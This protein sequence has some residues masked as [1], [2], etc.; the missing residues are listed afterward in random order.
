MKRTPGHFA[1]IFIFVTVLLCMV[2]FGV[3]IPVMPALIMEV[4]GGDLAEAAKWGGVLTLVYAIMQFF[5]MPI[6]GG[7]SDR[8]GRR[9]VLLGSLAAYSLDFLMLALAPNIAFL[10]VG[11]MLAGAFAATFSTAN[12]YVADITPPERR[13]G[14][15]GLMGAAFGLGFTIGPAIGGF[16]GEHFGPRAPFYFVAALGAANFLFG[17]V[18]APETL[19]A[20]NKR[21][22]DWRRANAIGSFLQLRRDYLAV[23]PIMLVVFL[24]QLGHWTTPAVWSYYA[25]ERFGWSLDE[26]GLSLVVVGVTAAIVQGGLTRIIV[27]KIGERAAVLVGLSIAVLAYA[28][29]AFA[30]KGWMVYTLI[31]IGAFGGLTLPALQAIMSRALPANAQGEL[32]GAVGAISGLTMIIS[33]WTMTQ[34]FSAFIKPGEPFK[35]GGVVLAAEG[36]P[37]YFP[38]APFILAS[39]LVVVAFLFFLFASSTKTRVAADAA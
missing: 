5:M 2:G 9:P 10:V 31:S 11:R 36:A 6:M 25:I 18:F 13:A 29:Y 38:G 26:I 34:L 3:T 23:L 21:P 39:A 33:P 24:Y 12:A 30:S 19:G 15:F 22:F 4:T 14:N 32:Q 37:F 8:F 35:I 16:L 27:P 7:L 28:G 1:L 17:L 20:E